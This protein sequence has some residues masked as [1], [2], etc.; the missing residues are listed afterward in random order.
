MPSRALWIVASTIGLFL[1]VTAPVFG[2][3]DRSLLDDPCNDAALSLPPSQLASGPGERLRANS[4]TLTKPLVEQLIGLRFPEL[5][6]VQVRTKSFNSDSDYFRTRFSLRR[7]LLLQR[8]RYFVEVNPRV[9]GLS[10]PPDGVCAIVGH[11]L[12]HVATLSH[13]SRLRFLVLIRLLSRGYTTR[14]ERRADLVAIQRGFA[15]GLKAYRAW[16]YH[17]IPARSVERKKR[18]YFTPAEI[19]AIVTRLQ[20]D[21]SLLDY[22]NR[23]VPLSLEQ[24]Q[25]GP[26]FL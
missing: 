23:H 24:I 3:P 22:W 16:I 26:G 4:I 19:D 11:E 21:P 20:H 14:F 10:S 15:P 18:D 13:G 9:F 12:A 8:M 5:K 7:F 25:Q 17:N 1:L 2:Q 6:H